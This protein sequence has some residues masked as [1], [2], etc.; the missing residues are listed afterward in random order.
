[1]N[2]QLWEFPNVEVGARLCELQHVLA[3]LD[4]LRVTDPRSE[5]LTPLGTVKHSITRY[6]IT[7]EAWRAEL[8]EAPSRR[9]ALHGQWLTPA[10]MQRL[11]FTSAHRKVLR[12]LTASIGG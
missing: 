10:Q 1:V 7:L 8:G 5:K 9:P 3:E 2:A 12:A 4:A 11:A 6:R